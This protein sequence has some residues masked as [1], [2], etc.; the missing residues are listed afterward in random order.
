M[1]I[2]SKRPRGE[3]GH[4]RRG[5]LSGWRELGLSERLCRRWG[6]IRPRPRSR[7][8]KPAR[9]ARAASAHAAA[10]QN[11]ASGGLA[12]LR[13]HGDAGGGREFGPV[14]KLPLA[15]C[16]GPMT[17]GRVLVRRA[18]VRDRLCQGRGEGSGSFSTVRAEFQWPDLGLVEAPRPAVRP[19]ARAGGR[20]GGRGAR[21]ATR[22]CGGP[23]HGD[24][25]GARHAGGRAGDVAFGESLGSP[26][27]P[28]E[29]R[30]KRKGPDG[31]AIRALPDAV[32]SQNTQTMRPEWNFAAYW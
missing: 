4:R 29:A 1:C 26:G 17:F 22:T 19:S 20:P 23:D 6:R 28:G 14:R 11:L 9:P 18:E 16:I 12:V 25:S 24:D 10:P 30:G 5:A 15:Y 13:G 31:Q 27:K 21:G 7:P 3:G 2:A 8:R 32:R